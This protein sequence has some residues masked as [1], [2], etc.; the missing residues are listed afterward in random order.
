VQIITTKQTVDSSQDRS[1]HEYAFVNGETGDFLSVKVSVTAMNMF[2]QHE[3]TEE[4]V[5][6]LTAEWGLYHKRS[7][8]TGCF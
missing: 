7:C 2:E 6:T 8:E 4:D 1:G 3:M 5:T